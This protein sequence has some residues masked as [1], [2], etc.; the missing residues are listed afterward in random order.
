V[1]PYNVQGLHNLC[2]VMVERGDLLGA[3]TCLADAHRLAPHEDYVKKHLEI[4]E[5]KIEE[6]LGAEKQR[7]QQQQQARPDLGAKR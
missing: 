3:R 2:V 5:S 4:V 7:Q 6:S 1:D